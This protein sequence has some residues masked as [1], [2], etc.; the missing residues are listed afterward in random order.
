MKEL[1]EKSLHMIQVLNIKSRKEYNFIV[2]HYKIL[3]AESMMYIS[4]TRKFDEVI[5]LD[6][7][8]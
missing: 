8:F 3:N 5:S 1:Y 7:S 2:K 4:Q 6:S